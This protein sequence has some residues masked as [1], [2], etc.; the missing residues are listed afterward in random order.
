MA[1]TSTGLTGSTNIEMHLAHQKEIDLNTVLDTLNVI[2]GVNWSFGTGANQVNMLYHA[3]LTREDDTAV[4]DISGTDIQ[5]AFGDNA[6]FAALKFL[7]IKNTDATEKLLLGA[8]ANHIGIFATLATDVLE[9]APGGFFL[10]CDPSA[11]GLDVTTNKN[12]AILAETTEITCDI[13]LM[14]LAT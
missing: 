7:Y 13:V 4:I 14:G 6:D 11:A 2:C 10:W 12:L 8:D 9:I 1:A 5:D 3:E